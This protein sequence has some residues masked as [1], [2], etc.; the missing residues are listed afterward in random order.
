MATS[1]W[2]GLGKGL[3]GAW[4]ALDFSR[5]LVFNLL[6]LLLV[7][8]AIA[9]WAKS[10]PPALQDKTTLVLDLQ[11]AVVEQF[12]GS[13]RDSVMAQVQGGGGESQVRL[14]DLIGVIDAAAKDPKVTQMLLQLDGL[15]SIGLP[16]LREVSAA[17][18]RFKAAGKPIVAYG[19]Y[20]EQ[21]AYYLAAQAGEVWM[22]PMGLMAFEGYGRLRTYYKDAL[23]KI[24]VQANVVRAG[25]FKSFGE[26]Y[27]R[28]GPSSEALEAETLLYGSLWADYAS[29]VEAARKLPPG[30]VQAF[31]DQ[32]PEKL[33]AA[34][35]DLAKVAVDAKFIDAL[36]APDEVRQ[37]MI[38]RGALDD[39]SKS[40]SKNFR[41]VSYQQ[42]RAYLKPPGSDAAV[43]IIVAEGNIVDGQADPGTVGGDS[44]A[45]LVKKAREDDKIKAVVLRVNS[46]G[47]SATASERVRRELE[48][49]R[50]AGKPVVVSMSNLAASGGYW[51]SMAADEVIAD[52]GT[53]TGS[54]GVVAILPT[55]KEAMDELGINFEG[56]VSTWLGAI[57]PRRELDPRLLPMVQQ[58]I[59]HGYADFITKAAQARKTTPEKIDAVGQGRVWTGAQA[60]E[61]GLIDRLGNLD[62]AVAAAIKRANLSGTTQARYIER[63][64]GKVQSLL[65]SLSSSMLTPLAQA[66]GV[67]MDGSAGWLTALALGPSSNPLPPLPAALLQQ[68]GADLITLLRMSQPRA[69]LPVQSLVHCWCMAP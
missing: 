34:G 13:V 6:F 27:N 56:Y 30:S 48:L 35:G 8:G 15:G 63:E 11:G 21:R 32:L 31:T 2:R 66:L 54:I 62:D 36:K 9:W 61:R 16:M 41:Q 44:T 7:V 19:S 26:V 12:S 23:D 25:K 47:G 55:A 38:E 60:L 52:P 39:K 49:T 65:M 33:A 58:L 68:A 14:R 24:G 4:Q 53:I 22:N 37:L 67:Q 46:P 29:G 59:N 18:Q 20:F 28:S 57:D 50:Q 1:I 51:I 43:G 10:G 64:P 17:L 42:Y 5:R 3:R 40:Q 69:P 45:E